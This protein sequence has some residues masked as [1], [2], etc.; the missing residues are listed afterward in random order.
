MSEIICASR[1]SSSAS[2]KWTKP[3]HHNSCF[4]WFRHIWDLL[5][6]S[7]A[8]ACLHTLQTLHKDTLKLSKSKAKPT[9]YTQVEYIHTL[10]T[11][12]PNP[13]PNPNPYPYPNPYPPDTRQLTRAQYCPLARCTGPARRPSPRLSLAPQVLTPPSLAPLSRYE[14]SAVAEPGHF[15]S[16]GGGGPKLRQSQH[17]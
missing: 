14:C 15:S 9:T 5:A 16:G 13:N 4:H 1:Q 6:E 11:L 12:T 7:A 3:K 8:A 10:L 17:R 2:Q